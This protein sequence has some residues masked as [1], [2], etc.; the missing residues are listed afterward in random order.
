ML[1]IIQVLMHSNYYKNLNI[2]YFILINYYKIFS[3]KKKKKL[4]FYI[5][6]YI[7]NN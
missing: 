6:G 3:I 2:I 1:S 5:V 7:L 4:A